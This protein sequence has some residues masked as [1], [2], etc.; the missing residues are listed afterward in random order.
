MTNLDGNNMQVHNDKEIMSGTI[1]FTCTLRMI[2]T[3][4]PPPPSAP[5]SA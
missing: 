2:I 3:H 5:L 1:I 4:P